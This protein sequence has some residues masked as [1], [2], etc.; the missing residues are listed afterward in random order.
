MAKCKAC[1]VEL[2]PGARFCD[3]CGTKVERICPRC[4]GVLREQAKY[5]DLCGIKLPLEQKIARPKVRGWWRQ[6]ACTL[7]PS[8]RMAPFWPPETTQFGQCDVETWSDI[9][10]I[11]AGKYHTV[12]VR[13]DGTVVA[14]GDRHL[15]PVPGGGL[16][17][18]GGRGRPGTAI[19]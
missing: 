12:G 16:D 2:R 18:C 10:T 14:A 8:E 4:G 3:M 6:A 11:A 19:P 7:W 5:C 13:K 9:V 1:G 15:W 17:R